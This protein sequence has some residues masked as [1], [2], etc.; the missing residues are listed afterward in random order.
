VALLRERGTS[1]SKIAAAVGV[2]RSYVSKVNAGRKRG[3][4]ADRLRQDIARAL[5]MEVAD[6]FPEGRRGSQAERRSNSEVAKVP[7][8]T[9]H[10]SRR[11]GPDE[12]ARQRSAT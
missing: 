1:L 4:R 6:A 7:L 9:F 8:L 5:G 12:A 2:D 11:A 10:N 3:P